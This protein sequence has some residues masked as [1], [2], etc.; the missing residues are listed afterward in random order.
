[1]VLIYLAWRGFKAPFPLFEFHGQLR[2]R[3]F[4]LPFDLGKDLL[5]LDDG[6]GHPV[7]AIPTGFPIAVTG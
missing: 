2:L 5:V 4:V 6:C 3:L 7:H 1:M